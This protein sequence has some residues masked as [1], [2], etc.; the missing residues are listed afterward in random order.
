MGWVQKN[1]KQKDLHLDYPNE[2]LVPLL[3]VN[4]FLTC[5]RLLRFRCILS[6]LD[7]GDLIH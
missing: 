6:D 2:S 4:T 5:R 7:L 1:N 3:V